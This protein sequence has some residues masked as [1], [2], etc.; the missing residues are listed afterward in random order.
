M[1]TSHAITPDLDKLEVAALYRRNLWLIL[2][3][4]TIRR[5][6]FFARTCYE[7]INIASPNE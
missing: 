5:N 4:Q 3:S 2:P 1:L 6:G 7:M